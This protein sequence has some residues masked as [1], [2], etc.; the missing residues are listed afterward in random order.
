M[1]LRNLKRQLWLELQKWSGC[2]H[3]EAGEIDRGQIIWGLVVRGKDFVILREQGNH[4]SILG[5]V[6]A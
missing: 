5:G 4:L 1:Y 6:T 2:Q 3:C